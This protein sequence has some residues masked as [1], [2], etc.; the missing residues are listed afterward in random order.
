[1][2]AITAVAAL[3]RFVPLV[4][5]RAKPELQGMKLLQRGSRQSVT[6]VTAAEFG[7]IVGLG[8]LSSLEEAP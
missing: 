3:P 5:L 7:V 2:V 8:G 6:P 1:M 4:E